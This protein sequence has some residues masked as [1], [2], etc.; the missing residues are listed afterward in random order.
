LRSIRHAPDPITRGESGEAIR[1]AEPATRCDR[2]RKADVF[3]IAIRETS[4][5]IPLTASVVIASRHPPAKPRSDQTGAR[6]GQRMSL[7][8]A[9]WYA[10][11]SQGVIQGKREFALGET[12]R[13]TPDANN[14]PGN[15]G[16]NSEDDAR[17]FL[18]NVS[19][20]LRSE[21]P[22][23]KFA[24]ATMSGNLTTDVLW[25]IVERIAEASEFIDAGETEN[26]TEKT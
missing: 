15:D 19:V 24:W 23:I 7:R 20:R 25:M 14:Q 4:N 21:D 3:Q 16:F 6:K 22:P 12:L 8:P 11:C 5:S 2:R 13:G 18:A 1:R 9:I 17:R 26:K 10:I